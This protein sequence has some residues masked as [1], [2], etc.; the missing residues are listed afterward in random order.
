MALVRWHL[1]MNAPEAAEK[2]A[3]RWLE[4]DRMDPDALIALAD[5]AALK[6]DLERSKAL[7]SS[8]VEADPQRAA[9]Q[10]RL[11]QLY[12][13]AG[14]A[15]LSCEHRL[16][17][18]L[19]ARSDVA[20]QVKAIRCGG[21]EA[22]IVAGL[23]EGVR[24]KVERALEKDPRESKVSGPFRIGATWDGDVDLDVIV[25]SPQGQ[26]VSWQGG[27]ELSVEDADANDREALSFKGRDNGRWTVLVAR[28]DGDERARAEGVLRITAHGVSR[29]VSFVVGDDEA[30]VPVAD[31][32]VAARFRWE[33]ASP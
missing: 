2:L 11:A 33:P 28:K 29:R 19:V 4:K 18:A 13:A 12:E 20:A 31:I 14:D 10:Q 25:V 22:R 26:V 32:D 3:L 6:G 30:V 9:N 1:R 17:R 7:L 21:R 23:E 5:V 15:T 8:A 16:S 24:A 27:A